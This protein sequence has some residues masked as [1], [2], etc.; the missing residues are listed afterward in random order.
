VKQEEVREEKEKKGGRGGEA[1]VAPGR[2]GSNFTSARRRGAR[3]KK[4]RC[5]S[6]TVVIDLFPRVPAKL[7]GKGKKNLPGVRRRQ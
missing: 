3:K 6:E 4:P 5:P 1:S 2:P 7:E